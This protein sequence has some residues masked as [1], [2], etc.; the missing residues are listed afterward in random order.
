MGF[1]YRSGPDPLS[2]KRR[3]GCGVEDLIPQTVSRWRER[4]FFDTA[5]PGGLAPSPNGLL[6][7]NAFLR[8]AFGEL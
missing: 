3:F 2:F 8:D 7:L 1:R 6:F 5:A 4:G